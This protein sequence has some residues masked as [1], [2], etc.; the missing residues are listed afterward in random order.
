M[1]DDNQLKAEVDRFILER[2][3][4]IPHLEAVLLLWRERPHTWSVEDL[5]KRL[6]VKPEVAKII[7]QDLAR[8]R[9]LSAAPEPRHYCYL[10]TPDNDRLL[11]SLNEAY[12]H[13][14]IRIS[15]MIHSKASSAVREFARAFRLNKEHE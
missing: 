11:S 7:L 9:L 4:S 14:M 1:T 3:E 2:I 12:R 8:D 10:S 6:W 5:A 15:N 13:E